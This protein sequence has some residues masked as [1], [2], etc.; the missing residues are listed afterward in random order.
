VSKDDEESYNRKLRPRKYCDGR[1]STGP[2]MPWA[3]GSGAVPRRNLYMGE[4]NTEKERI[5]RAGDK[6]EEEKGRRCLIR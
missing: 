5:S 3:R 4:N 2:S 1:A 6:Q